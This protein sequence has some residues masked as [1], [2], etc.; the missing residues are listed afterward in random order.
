[1]Y[2]YPYRIYLTTELKDQHKKVRLD[3]NKGP[4]D[5]YLWG[6]CKAE[7]RRHQ[8]KTLEDLMEVVLAPWTKLRLGEP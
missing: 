4:C 8:P 5:F 2:F 6:I 7:I 1:M 3:Y